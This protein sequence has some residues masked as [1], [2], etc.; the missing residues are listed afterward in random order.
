MRSMKNR[1]EFGFKTPQNR[2]TKTLKSQAKYKI[3]LRG[4]DNDRVSYNKNKRN[5]NSLSPLK[6]LKVLRG[7]EE[8]KSLSLERKQERRVFFCHAT[9]SKF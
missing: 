3:R 4:S 2:L 9:H 7:E 8:R 6:D 5:L 1:L